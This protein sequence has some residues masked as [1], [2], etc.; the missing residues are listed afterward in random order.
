MPDVGTLV[1]RN[2]ATVPPFTAGHLPNS[3]RSL[4]YPP[5]LHKPRA[6]T[7]LYNIGVLTVH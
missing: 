3:C 4:A 2:S 6:A 5:G 1:R 7:F